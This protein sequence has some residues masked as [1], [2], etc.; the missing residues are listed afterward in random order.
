MGFSS[1][2][3][4]DPHQIVSELSQI[5]G[6]PAGVRDLLGGVGETLATY[7]HVVIGDQNPFTWCFVCI[8]RCFH[9]GLYH[10]CCSLSH[11]IS[12]NV[13]ALI[14]FLMLLSWDVWLSAHVTS[15]S[16]CDFSCIYC[17]YPQ[18]SLAT[19]PGHVVGHSVFCS[20][21]LCFV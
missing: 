7:T 10:L 20:F 4:L 5:V 8:Q 6:H 1:W 9:I 15:S 18:R 11:Q 2:G 19:I 14:C 16:S 21:L 17:K 3:S 13:L 12:P